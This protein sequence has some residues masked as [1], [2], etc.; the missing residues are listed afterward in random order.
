MRSIS[1]IPISWVC[2][3]TSPS[4]SH[5][6]PLSLHH[7]LS[8]LFFSCTLSHLISGKYHVL[9]WVPQ[10]EQGLYPLKCAFVCYINWARQFAFWTHFGCGDQHVFGAMYNSCLKPFSRFLFPH[11]SSHLSY[12]LWESLIL[13]LQMVWALPSRKF[14]RLLIWITINSVLTAGLS[15]IMS[16][17]S[18]LE[19]RKAIFCEVKHY[20]NFIQ[21][22]PA[23]LVDY[24]SSPYAS[25][26]LVIHGW[27]TL[28]RQASCP[29]GFYH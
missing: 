3:S 15:S 16:A 8:Q 29:N 14:Y 11:C 25:I 2:L 20:L 23:S 27:L 4:I 12:R 18:H 24:P 1:F 9:G 5:M 22:V 26:C 19:W 10:I 13:T 17:F 28:Y 6:L 21:C 7:S